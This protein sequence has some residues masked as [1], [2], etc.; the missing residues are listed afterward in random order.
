MLSSRRSSFGRQ[1]TLNPLKRKV[2]DRYEL[3][4]VVETRSVWV[5]FK[6]HK[7]VQV[8]VEQREPS[9]VET[10]S[11]VELPDAKGI[12]SL[13]SLPMDVFLEVSKTL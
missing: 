5:A 7:P 2:A 3:D 12:V 13:G 10:P 8:N 6:K 9:P 4:D 1:P 11:T